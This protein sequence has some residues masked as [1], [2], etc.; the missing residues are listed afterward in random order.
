MLRVQFDRAVSELNTWVRQP[1]RD[2]DAIP[3]AAR[4]KSR[5]PTLWNEPC[6][7]VFRTPVREACSLCGSRARSQKAVASN[8]ARLPR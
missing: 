8:G 7:A 3:R 6:R 2:D 1:D 4:K 5:G